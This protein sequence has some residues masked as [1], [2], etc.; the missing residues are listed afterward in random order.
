MQEVHKN[1]IGTK[2]LFTVKDGDST[3]DISGAS[4]KQIHFRKPSSSTLTKTASFETDGSN[5]QM[6]YT[7]VDG[8]IDEVGEWE[9]QV[10]LDW[11]A[12]EFRSNVVRFHVYNNLT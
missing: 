9:A 11:G 8:D 2:F 5:G 10:F 3:T 6:Y 4:T 7:T 12:S 1:D